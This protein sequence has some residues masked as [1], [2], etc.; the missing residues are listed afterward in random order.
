LLCLWLFLGSLLTVPPPAHAAVNY[1][2][3][4][5]G[6]LIAVVDATGEAAIYQYDAV[7]NLLSITRQ[8]PGVVSILNF[9]PK[10]GPVGTTVTISGT[11]F[12]TTASQNTVTFNGTPATVTAATTT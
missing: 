9:T 8:N 5:L 4:D 11:G 1:I 7:G 2:Y 6:R 10:S 12:S 3:D